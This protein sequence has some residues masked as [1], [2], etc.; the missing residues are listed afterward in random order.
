MERIKQALD[1][2]RAE[3]DTSGPD[4]THANAGPPSK[5]P[6]SAVET[7]IQ[8]SQTKIAKLD[9]V[10]LQN[11]RVIFGEHDRVGLTAYKINLNVDQLGRGLLCESSSATGQL[12][13][14]AHR[15]CAD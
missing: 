6:A 9:S 1:K 15:R 13:D 4:A 2:A 3:R 7:A 12:P 5:A 14:Y 8:Y 10:T 11:N